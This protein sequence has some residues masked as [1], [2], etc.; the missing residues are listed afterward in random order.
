[1]KPPYV[2]IIAECATHGR[3]TLERKPNKVLGA[4]QP[5]SM[6]GLY[7]AVVCDKC[8]MWATIIEQTIIT[9]AP[10]AAATDTT[11]TLPGLEG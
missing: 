2:K 3:F 5:A 4:G 1:M 10:V 6:Q 8:R 11:G 7:Q 9:A